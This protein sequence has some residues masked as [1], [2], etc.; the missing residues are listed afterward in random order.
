MSVSPA[1]LAATIAIAASVAGP[2]YAQTTTRVSV[3][4]T[5]AEGNGKSFGGV[6]AVSADGRYVVFSS[7]ASNLVANDNNGCR[8]IFVLDRATG[9]TQRVSVDS[10]GIEANAD[11]FADEFVISA[12]GRFVAFTSFASNLV[13]NDT[14]LA[15]DIFVH[16][17]VT[18]TTERANVDS[19]GNQAAGGLAP[20]DSHNPEISRDGAIVSFCSSA[21][22]LVG[23]DTNGYFDVFVHDRSTGITE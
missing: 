1:A 5:G 14:N 22:N 8:D 9:T 12:D 10:A 3:D 17:R 2:M 20:P 23:S 4:S 13:A 15:M 7:E 21:A 6:S 16:D 11:S 18:G 19:S